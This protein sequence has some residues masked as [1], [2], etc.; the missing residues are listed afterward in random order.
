MRII[1]IWIFIFLGA[2]IHAQLDSNLP[3]IVINTSG[4]VSIPDDP[5]VDATMGIIY[6]GA[7]N[8]NNETDA[9]NEYYGNIGIEL[10]GS[11]SQGFPKKQWGIETRDGSGFSKDE[12]IFGMAPDNDWVLYAPYSDKSLIRNVLA[13]EMGWD[14]SGY[15]PRTKIV[16]VILN[17]QYEGVYI[18][19]EKIKRKDGKVGTNDVKP[20]DVSG[21]ELTG[22]Y[23]VKVDKLTADGIVAWTS[24][25]KPYNGASNSE[26]IK[27]QLHDPEY[28][29]LNSTQRNYIKNFVNDFEDALD[30]S[31]YRDLEEGY[32][33]YIN[34]MSFI[35]FTLVN[36]ISKN[37]DGYR[38]SSFFHK[39]RASEGGKIHAGPLWDFNL[40]FGNSNYC[41]GGNT[42][43]WELDFYK[44]CTGGLQNPFWWKKLLKDPAYAD[45]MNCRWNEMRDGPWSTSNLMS[46]IDEL[47]AYLEESQQRNF[48]RW[49]IL[50]AYVW[51]NNYIG[52]SYADEISYLKSWI[53]SRVNWLDNNM[54][55]S[56][57]SSGTV[58]SFLSIQREKNN[59]TTVFP[60]TSSEKFNFTFNTAVSNATL[61]VLDLSGKVVYSVNGVSGTEFILH[62]S[63]VKPGMYLYN[64]ISKE[65]QS[66]GKIIIKQ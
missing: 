47:A 26:K 55:G 66:T 21:N 48:Q 17:G 31:N 18:F 10:R 46:R 40:A 11:S 58:C 2:S 15:A 14:L 1:L 35:D 30:G 24:K 50:G 5:K 49:P 7:G 16:E 34:V 19:T 64:I 54:F 6:N 38:I 9:F 20:E 22:D 57:S 12:T 33:A 59:L 29:D 28:A 25:Y 13:Y 45:L 39:V 36:E 56:S 53:T 60:T 51:P 43:G 37:V 65:T 62:L 61:E 42:N 27:F 3:I 52:N 8:R 41:N 4:G 44:T 32:A 63:N 23:I